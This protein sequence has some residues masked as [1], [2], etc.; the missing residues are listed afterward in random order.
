M[1][2]YAEMIQRRYICWMTCILLLTKQWIPQNNNIL[3]YIP[4]ASAASIMAWERL[5]ALVVFT[6][7]TIF[8]CNNQTSLVQSVIIISSK[9]AEC[10]SNAGRINKRNVKTKREFRSRRHKAGYRIASFTIPWS[11]LINTNGTEKL[12]Q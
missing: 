3:I 10:S 5:L 11:S 2:R 6:L 1:Y 4:F 12:G 8:C 9:R 7:I